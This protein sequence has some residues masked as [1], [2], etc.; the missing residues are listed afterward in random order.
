MVWK[1]YVT[2]KLQ[3]IPV[4]SLNCT[5]SPATPPACLTQGPLEVRVVFSSFQEK[6]LDVR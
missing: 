3:I 4:V 1:C 5:R 2:L 6:A